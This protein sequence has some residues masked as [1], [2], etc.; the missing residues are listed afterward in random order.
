MWGFSLTNLRRNLALSSSSLQS[1][2]FVIGQ[3]VQKSEEYGEIRQVSDSEYSKRRFSRTK[4]VRN[5]FGNSFFAQTRPLG[6]FNM[7]RPFEIRASILK[8]PFTRKQVEVV[9]TNSKTE[10]TYVMFSYSA[11]SKPITSI[12]SAQRLSAAENIN[13]KV[14]IPSDSIKASS[15]CHCE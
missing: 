1:R 9:R 8:R 7:N 4:R 11:L 13:H 12:K 6:N 15:S 10:V 5:K 3:K 14:G 2:K